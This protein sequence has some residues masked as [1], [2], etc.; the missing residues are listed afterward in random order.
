FVF[1]EKLCF[2]MPFDYVYASKK[3]IKSYA[4]ITRSGYGRIDETS[5]FEGIS[6]AGI[7]SCVAIV[8]HCAELKRTVLINTTYR[9]NVKQILQPIFDWLVAKNE[10]QNSQW[11]SIEV[12]VLRGYLH[13]EPLHPLASLVYDCFMQ[14]LNG[15]LNEAYKEY[16]KYIDSSCILYSSSQG[17]VLVDKGTAL[18]T[19]LTSP[20]EIPPSRIYSKQQVAREIFANDLMPL[21]FDKRNIVKERHLQFDVNHFTP[22]RCGLDKK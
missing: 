15:F 13:R 2:E 3:D 9:M 4:A 11:N 19:I 17:A 12:A 16:S 21:L 22:H 6:A 5:S 8:G 14:E 7:T 10:E 18:I 1:C 20:M